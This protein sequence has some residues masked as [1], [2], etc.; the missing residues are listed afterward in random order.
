MIG[1]RAGDNRTKFG[2][3]AIYLGEGEVIAVTGNN[4]AINANAVTL[5]MADLMQS[6]SFHFTRLRR[7]PAPK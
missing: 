5:V 7:L 1:W 4:K 6:K 2:F 3:V